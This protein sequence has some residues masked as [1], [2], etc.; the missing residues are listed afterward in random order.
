MKL[1]I[2]Q[3]IISSLLAEKKTE[4]TVFKQFALRKVNSH[5]EPA[6]LLPSLQS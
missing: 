3:T 6:H 4:E 1:L 5:M 2:K